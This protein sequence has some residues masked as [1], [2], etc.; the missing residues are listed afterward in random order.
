MLLSGSV[1][2]VL[3]ADPFGDLQLKGVRN[4]AP[5]LILNQETSTLTLNWQRSREMLERSRRS[6]AG[7]VSSP[8]RARAPVPLFFENGQGSHLWDVDGNEYIDYQ[9]AWGPM[10]LGYNHP[11]MVESLR[12]QVDTPVV[13]AF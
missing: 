1:Q 13:P 10:I 6:L 2:S 7:G 8:F 12:R 11:A 9:L 4:R 3:Y 5:S